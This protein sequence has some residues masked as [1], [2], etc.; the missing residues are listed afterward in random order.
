MTDLAHLALLLSDQKARD[1]A[2]CVPVSPEDA[3]KV[4]FSRNGKVNPFHAELNLPD[5]RDASGMAEW[6]CIA[7]LDLHALVASA[8]RMEAALMLWK[9]YAEATSPNYDSR[10]IQMIYDDAMNATRAALEEKP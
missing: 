10:G 3:D 2:P 9:R 6:D 4:V 1:E 7:T 5:G 8:A